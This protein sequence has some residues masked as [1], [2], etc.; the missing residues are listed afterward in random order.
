MKEIFSETCSSKNKIGDSSTVEVRSAPVSSKMSVEVAK[1]QSSEGKALSAVSI[2]EATLP[3]MGSSND[4]SKQ[5]GSGDGVKMEGDHTPALGKAPTSEINPSM[6]EIKTSHGPVEKMRELIRAS[7]ENPVMGSN[8]EVNH[9]VLD[10]GDRDNITSQ[11]PAPEGLLGDG[12]DPPM[13]TLSVSDVTEH[14]RSD[15][16]YRT[17]A[18]K[19]SPK[20]SPHV[21]SLGNRTISIKPDYTDYFS[22]G[23][24]TLVA[25][26]SDSRNILSV[27]DSVSRSSNKPS[28]KESLDSSLEIRDD[29]AKTHIQ[30][31]VDI[32]KVEGE[33]VCKMQIDPAVSEVCFLF[34]CFSYL[35]FS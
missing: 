15:S 27:A 29:E 8:M 3:V 24:V 25:D 2:L 23:T 13:V 35:D 10:A 20:S 22:L 1:N 31:G 6:L 18:S 26:H 9:S 16:G 28:V 30:S 21:V 5:P 11:R 17:Q 7:T 19:A 4:D 34:C 14:P 12:G 32:T 33:E